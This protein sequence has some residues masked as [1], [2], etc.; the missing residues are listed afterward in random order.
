MYIISASL[1]SVYLAA[2]SVV[3]APTHSRRSTASQNSLPGDEV[4]FA[5]LVD[6]D[7]SG[8]E[9][10][11]QQ[12]H[13]PVS[14]IT[15][16]ESHGQAIQ[17]GDTIRLEVDQQSLKDAKTDEACGSAFRPKKCHEEGVPN[18]VTIVFIKEDGG[19]WHI[20]CEP[21]NFE[22][23]PSEDPSETEEPQPS[24]TEDKSSE[25]EKKIK[26]KNSG[27][28]ISVNEFDIEVI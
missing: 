22:E 7:F 17:D 12:I 25:I 18:P 24:A 21:Q 23:Q 10:C 14:A 28:S 5:V 1:L 8:A 2:Y 13:A 20:T 4:P 6:I 16:P 9:I 26:E 15:F 19:F 3:A 27:K 11:G